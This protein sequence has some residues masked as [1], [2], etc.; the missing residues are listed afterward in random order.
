MKLETLRVKNQNDETF[1]VESLVFQT[2][3][4]TRDKEHVIYFS[5][6]IL[7]L[8]F[9]A[10][11]FLVTRSTKRRYFYIWSQSMGLSL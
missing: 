4:T 8:C 1:C 2:E 3:M 11:N 5:L 6:F 7:I 10:F 9:I